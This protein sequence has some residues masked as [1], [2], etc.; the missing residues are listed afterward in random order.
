MYRRYGKRVLEGVSRVL[1]EADWHKVV[2]V[3]RGKGALIF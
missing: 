1:R 2:T 3:S